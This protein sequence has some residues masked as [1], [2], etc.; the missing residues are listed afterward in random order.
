MNPPFS[1]GR[2]AL[3]V[4]HAYSLLA[5]GGGLVAVMPGSF[6]GKQVVPNVDAEF[7]RVYE[8]EFEATSVAVVLM[9]IVRPCETGPRYETAEAYA[10]A[11]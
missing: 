2:A 7:S 4:E 6:R 1:D 9:R 10:A 11:A 5:P 3:H 8:G